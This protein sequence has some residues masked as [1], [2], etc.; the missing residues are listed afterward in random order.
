MNNFFSKFNMKLTKYEFKLKDYK[1]FN[2][3]NRKVYLFEDRNC[4]DLLDTFYKRINDLIL[5]KEHF[6]IIRIADG[7]FQFLLGKNEFNLRKPFHKLVIHLT[8]QLF[9]KILKPKFEAKSRTYTSGVYSHSD[10][11]NVKNQ[12]SECLKYI[13]KE[14]VLALYTTIKPGFYTEQ[15]LP[16]LFSFFKE[17]GI[18][19]N[20]HNYVPFYFIYIILT[21]KKYSKIYINKNIHLVTSFNTERKEKIENTLNSFGVESITWTEISRERSLF[22]TINVS[23][24]VKDADIIFVGA[25]IGKVHIF[26]QLKN[27]QAVIIDAGYIFETWQNPELRKERDYCLVHK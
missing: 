7:E 14:G 22:D 10:R 21:N 15:Y 25:G 13:S 23:N 6:P 24:K 5:K 4:D 16:R 1:N 12:Y 8:K 3:E 20:E 9:E 17:N 26:N 2:S 18:D 11:Y 27:I 19:V